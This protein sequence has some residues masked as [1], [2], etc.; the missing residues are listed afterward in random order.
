MNKF[1][2]LLFKIK[3]LFKAFIFLDYL[4]RFKKLPPKFNLTNNKNEIIMSNNKIG[5]V[6]CAFYMDEYFQY[7]ILDDTI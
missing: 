2:N 3:P 5:K 7:E 6:L 4:I 1:L